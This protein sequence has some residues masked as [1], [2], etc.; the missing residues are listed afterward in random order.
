MNT[1]TT[2]SLLETLSALEQQYASRISQRSAL[3]VTQVE[4]VEF[5]K[6]KD[7][8][9][10]GNPLA[11]D[12]AIDKYLGLKPSPGQM[13]MLYVLAGR[14][15]YEWDTTFQQFAIAI[16]Q[17]GGK[18]SYIIAPFLWY[19][20]Y[21]IANMKDPWKYFSR[22]FKVP[23]DRSKKFEM[24]N[25][26]MVTERQAKDVHFAK[27][28]AIIQRTTDTDGQNW[29]K[30]YTKMDG[31]RSF[32]DIKTNQI[33]IPTEAGCGDII[34]HSFDSTASAPEGLELICAIIDEPSRANTAASYAVAENLWKVVVGNL[35]TRYMN[36]VG[37][38][39]AFS[40]LNNSEYDFTYTLLQ[41]AEEEKKYTTK[42]TIYAI[43]KSSFEMN[44][45]ITEEDESVRSAYR[46]DPSDARARYEGIKGASK[47]GFYQPHPEKVRE[48]FYEGQ[49]PVQYDYKITQRTVENPTTL[50]REI[51]KYIGIDLTNVKGDNKV[52]GFALD[53]AEKYD[54][55]VLKGGYIE[56]MDEMKDELFIDN[57]KELIVVNQKPVIDI[58][59]V[60]QPRNG[61]TVDY[62]NIGE[63]IGI[64]LQK[65]RNTVFINSDKY[66]SVK[67]SQ[68]IIARGVLSETYS[69]GNTQQMRLY[70]RMR[71]MVWNNVPQILID[72]NHDLSRKGITKNVGEW[73]ILEHERLLKIN[74]NKVDHPADGSK[75]MADVDAILINDL[76]KLEAKCISAATGIET[77]PQ[78]K[79]LDIVEKY[80]I[81][82]QR[83]KNNSVQRLKRLP[84]LAQALGLSMR[85]ARL[86][87]EYVDE[88]FAHN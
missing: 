62:L 48:A 50:T 27:M 83:L 39:I 65:Y 47:E 66:Q 16:G 49:S 46:T 24:S 5:W 34:L 57:E 56:T 44:P 4:G 73:N 11:I 9:K 80:M 25:S 22:F 69:F 20:T 71:W 87:K 31:R 58:C 43:N 82:E 76:T 28:K 29:F 41:R 12:E 15:P 77:M 79:L 55:F 10:D 64:L 78:R 32:G 21:K 52:R 60:W 33:R 2:S 8:W 84:L 51:K 36:G 86:L 40:Y 59:I 37:K 81:E 26:S 18:N 72:R 88:T 7:F 42:P 17:G 45:N 74:D 63:V 70:K 38:A 30:K 68:E 13:E 3:P 19:L 54:S 14:D 53:P 75:D 1:K 6:S 85:D 35:N 67:L 61:V 23:L